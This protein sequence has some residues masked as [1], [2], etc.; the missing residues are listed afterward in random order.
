[1]ICN[2]L[3]IIGKRIGD[4]EIQ[5]ILVESNVAVS[6]SVAGILAGK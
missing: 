3:C 4:S 5:D 2:Y 6:G 1:M